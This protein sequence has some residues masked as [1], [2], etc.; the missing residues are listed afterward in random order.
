MGAAEAGIKFQI[1]GLDSY[2]VCGGLA[3]LCGACDEASWRSELCRS[4]GS[5]YPD[6]SIPPRAFFPSRRISHSS[7]NV[8]INLSL[9]TPSR[10]LGRQSTACK[11]VPSPTLFLTST[12]ASCRHFRQYGIVQTQVPSTSIPKLRRSRL[13]IPHRQYRDHG[14]AMLALHTASSAL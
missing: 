10:L 4:L 13:N 3:S 6:L 7:T 5:P 14:A 12:S 1:T 9:P 2:G 11:N 8:Y